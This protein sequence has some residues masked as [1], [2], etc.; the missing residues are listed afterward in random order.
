MIDTKEYRH[1][2]PL[3]E[4]V[5]EGLFDVGGGFRNVMRIGGCWERE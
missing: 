1:G 3:S 4:K 2:Y 5:G